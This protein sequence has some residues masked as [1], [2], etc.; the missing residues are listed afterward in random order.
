MGTAWGGEEVYF[1]PVCVD[2]DALSWLHTHTY[3]DRRS[4]D[5]GTVVILTLKDK[6]TNN[7]IISN[8][9]TFPTVTDC[10]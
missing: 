6:Q 4:C 5:T 10:C 3:C 9:T 2:S 1:N 8:E 7:D